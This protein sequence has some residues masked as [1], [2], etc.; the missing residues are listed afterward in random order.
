MAGLAFKT[1]IVQEQRQRFWVYG[2]YTHAEFQKSLPC[3]QSLFAGAP[4]WVH[5]RLIAATATR[6]GARAAIPGD[7]TR[8]SRLPAPDVLPNG[9]ELWIT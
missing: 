8:I 9:V 4:D 7:A 1:F 2:F 6:D 5:G 3:R